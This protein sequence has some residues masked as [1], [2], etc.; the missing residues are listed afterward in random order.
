MER[1][2]REL[3]VYKLLYQLAMKV[4]EESKRFPVEERYSLTDQIRRSSRSACAN[5]AEGYRKRRYPAHFVLKLADSDGEVAETTVHLSFARDCGYLSKEMHDELF[6][7][8][9]EAGRMLGG[10]I[11]KPEL[12]CD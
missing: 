2:F 10:M 11:A 8:Y 6:Q 7:G 5:L 12:F 9:S 3:K 1:G 4:F